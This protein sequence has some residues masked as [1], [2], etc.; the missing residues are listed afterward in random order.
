MKLASTLAHLKPVPRTRG[1]EPAILE[2]VPFPARAGMNR[3]RHDLPRRRSRS[4]PRTRGD[5][6]SLTLNV[7]SCRPVPRTR[8]DEPMDA[9]VRVLASRTT[10]PRT[11]GD[12]PSSSSSGMTFPFPAR[13]G[14]NRSPAGRLN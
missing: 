1:D 8:G 7:A 12:E 5:E 4:V 3:R 10:V 13:A 11:R 6:P 9:A 14:M 2:A